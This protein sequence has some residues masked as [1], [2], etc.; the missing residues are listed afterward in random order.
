MAGTGLK[1]ETNEYTVTS[2]NSAEGG[3]T[4]TVTVNDAHD[5][6]GTKLWIV[7]K[8]T[9]NEQ[10]GSAAAVTLSNS[11]K[12]KHNATAAS[13]SWSEAGMTK[14]YVGSFNFTKVGPDKELLKNAKFAVYSGTQT[15]GTPLKFTKVDNGNDSWTYYYN[16]DGTE[17]EVASDANGRVVVYGL[18][19]KMTNGVEGDGKYTLKE[20]QAPTGYLNVESTMPV[21]TVEA[22]LNDNA[23]TLTA[24][25]GLESNNNTLNLATKTDTEGVRV[26]N[27][28]SITQLPLTGGAGIILFS[29]IAALLV[30]VAAIVTVKIRFVRRELQD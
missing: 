29:V 4:M 14:Q 3:K 8:A 28:K 16:P 13:A 27:V 7:Y 12:V 11:A 10:A 19:A 2:S 22:Q 5:W 15:T 6:Y 9:V 30:A 21:F 26:K 25:T 23:G 24:T 17:T 18:K 20:T 1:M